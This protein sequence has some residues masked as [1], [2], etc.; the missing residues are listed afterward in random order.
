MHWPNYQLQ[1]QKYIGEAFLKCSSVATLKALFSSRL[2]SSCWSCPCSGFTGIFMG[3]ECASGQVRGVCYWMPW[4]GYVGMW[5]DAPT[6][7]PWNIIA[8]VQICWGEFYLVD[9]PGAWTKDHLA[10][11]MDFLLTSL[12]L[13]RGSILAKG[14]YL[15]CMTPLNLVPA[16]GISTLPYIWPYSYSCSFALSILPLFL[17]RHTLWSLSPA[18]LIDPYL[19]L[20]LLYP[21][22]STSKSTPSLPLSN[23]SLALKCTLPWLLSSLLC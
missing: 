13:G 14:D 6:E 10:Y 4:P 3:F 9:S 19:S 20:L 11:W 1:T 15:L 21:L 18:P 16:W 23:F 2:E 5:K 17:L 7:M 8:V 22:T 12:Y